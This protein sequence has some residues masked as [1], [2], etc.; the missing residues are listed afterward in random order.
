MS[1]STLNVAIPGKKSPDSPLCTSFNAQWEYAANSTNYYLDVST[2]N[3][4]A[5]YVPGYYNLQITGGG[6]TSKLVTGLNPA[7]QYFYRVRA[8]GCGISGNSDTMTISTTPVPTGSPVAAAATNANCNYVQLNWSAV[9]NATGYYLDISADAN[10]TTFL[11]GFESFYVAGNSFYGADNL[12]AGPL[13]YKV[14][15]TNICNSPSPYSIPFK[16]STTKP[17]AGTITPNKSICTGTSTTV[18]VLDSTGSIQWQQ[19]ANG[20]TGWT[21]VSTGSGS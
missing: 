18:S 1:T 13:Y 9:A 2:S 10:F 4:F 11:S 14:R 3:T 5:D 7:T 19:S 16:F 12:P 20:A 17:Y 8:G 6:T 21:N 15:A